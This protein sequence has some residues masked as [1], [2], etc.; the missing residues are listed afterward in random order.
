MSPSDEIIRRAFEINRVTFGRLIGH[1]TPAWRNTL[2]KPVGIVNDAERGLRIIDVWV[3]CWRVVKK[4]E[5]KRTKRGTTRPAIQVCPRGVESGLGDHDAGFSGGRKMGRSGYEKGDEL[6]SRN[7]SP[8]V[9]I[10]DVKWN[11]STRSE[12]K[13]VSWSW[14]HLYCDKHHRR[15]KIHNEHSI[16]N[17]IL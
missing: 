16:V 15:S 17:G 4:S 12:M 13:C 2:K 5:I 10:W 7:T 8:S 9:I 1:W 14:N 11:S 3:V 6:S